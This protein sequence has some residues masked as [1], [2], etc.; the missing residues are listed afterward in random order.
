MELDAFSRFA[1]TYQK[2]EIIF[3]EYEPGDTFYL[4]QSG[5]VQL[6]KIIGNIE[7]I[8]DILQPSEMFGEMAI[9]EDSPRSATA[10]ALDPVK[11]LEFNRA[12]FEV[13]MMGNPQIALKLLKLFTKRIYDQKRRFMIL[14][15]EDP[16]AKVAD[17]F[18]MLDETQPNIDKTTDQRE[19]KTTVEDIAHW[20]GMNAD[21]TR[22]ILNHFVNQRRVEIFP[23]RIVVKNIN[24]FQRFVNSRRKKT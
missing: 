17:V 9:L 5:R 22:D 20:A 8:L 11:V 21:Q 16:Q 23:D 24:D 19:F 14:T 2:G 13:L 7:K 10:I 15:L 3:S 12:N 18:L 4:I 1:R 6:V